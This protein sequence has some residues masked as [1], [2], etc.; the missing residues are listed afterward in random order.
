MLDSSSDF[1]CEQL[2]ERF[3]ATLEL[4]LIIIVIVVFEE[5]V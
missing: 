5:L 2:R 1:D 3:T 4:W